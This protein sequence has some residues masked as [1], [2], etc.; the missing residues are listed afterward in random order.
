MSPPFVGA[1]SY[2]ARVPHDETPARVTPPARASAPARAAADVTI[3][4]LRPDEAPALR[5]VMQ[6][7]FVEYTTADFSYGTERETDESIRAE[8]EGDGR[9]I[10]AFE[11]DRLVAVV[12][13]RPDRED[14]LRYFWRLSVLPSYRGRGLAD[15][16]VDAVAEAAREQGLAGIACNVVPRH[17]GL[18]DLYMRHGMRSLGEEPFT[19]PDGTAMALIRL[20]GT[21]A[22]VLG[23]RRASAQA[24]VRELG[25][26]DAEELAA[27]IHAAFREFDDTPAP[28]GAMLETA[29]TLR[30]ELAAGTRA[31]GIVVDGRIVAAMKLTLSRTRALHLARL[32]VR[33]DGRGVGH[34]RTLVEWAAAEAASQGLRA[35]TCTVRAEETGLIDLYEHL[36]F[37]QAAHGVH[38]SLTGRPH[39][40]VQMRRVL[41]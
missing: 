14:H 7:A 3:R 19:A 4:P 32:G 5:A 29:E 31:V 24:E 12:K 26:A 1:R 27:T 9:A 35:V 13:H 16:L 30:E 39:H 8:L 23:A 17:A 18:V 10:G 21:T 25:P 2:D 28:S 37:V 22:D 15:A 33:P 11:G 38:V 6:T 36:G 41:R 20:E 40:V 34:A